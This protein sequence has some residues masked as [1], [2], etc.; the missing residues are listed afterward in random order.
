MLS[1]EAQ[2]KLLKAIKVSDETIATLVDVDTDTDVDVPANLRIYDDAAYSELETN[3]RKGYIKDKD[4]EEIWCRKMN[5]EYELGLTGAAAKDKKKV[6]EA[7]KSKHLKEANITP[8][9]WEP[10]FKTLQDSV[11]AK[12]GEILTVKQQLE[13]LQAEKKYRKLF[14]PDMSDA[15]D[16][17]EWIARLQKTFTIK[18]EGDVEG[19]WDNAKGKFVMDDK[20]NVLPYKE[21]WDVLRTDDRFKSWHKA[22]AAEPAAQTQRPTHDPKS[23]NPAIPKVPKFKDDEAIRKEVDKKF[24]P[25]QKGKMPNWASGRRDLFQRL[26]AETV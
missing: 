16:E 13:A 17:D 24:P 1:K 4:S 9:E 20:A 2:K 6:L 18:P 26:K 15:L 21:A 11:T 23:R 5:E 3:L 25:D 14:F 10:K 22:K 7:M 8:A 12:D 19:L